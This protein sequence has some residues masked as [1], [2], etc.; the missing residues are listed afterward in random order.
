MKRHNRTT[1][2]N[3]GD[4]HLVTSSTHDVRRYILKAHLKDANDFRNLCRAFY[5]PHAYDALNPV[6]AYYA[7]KIRKY[8][9]QVMMDELI[10]YIDL[11]TTR[12]TFYDVLPSYMGAV[13][14]LDKYDRMHL[15]LYSE[16][17]TYCSEIG[18]TEIYK[19][20]RESP[21]VCPNIDSSSV[22]LCYSCRELMHTN[23]VDQEEYNCEYH[24]E[25]L[26][27]AITTN[28]D[29]SCFIGL[30]TIKIMA[31]LIHKS[32][33]FQSPY[34]LD[35][36][37]KYLHY[38]IETYRIRRVCFQSPLEHVKPRYYYLYADLKRA[39]NT[40][41]KKMFYSVQPKVEVL[42]LC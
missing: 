14:T 7:L 12:L 16:N 29:P 39:I 34:Y 38:V 21:R 15:F 18:A 13:R 8:N 17:C 10:S 6:K 33:A 19:L 31:R 22:F 24:D 11:Y 36:R 25:Q 32:I 42:E 1:A 3:D 2:T 28:D 30:I 23:T 4:C 26:L 37:K 41:E 9:Q 40:Q 27:K 5:M 35:E 20:H